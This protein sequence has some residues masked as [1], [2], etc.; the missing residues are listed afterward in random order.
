MTLATFMHW[1]AIWADLAGPSL[2]SIDE[3]IA[4]YWPHIEI[5]DKHDQS[6]GHKPVPRGAEICTS[7]PCS[8]W[9]NHYIGDLIMR[10]G[11]NI[12]LLTTVLRR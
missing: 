1:K 8:T 4:P 7:G 3:S 6:L 5:V 10:H 2:V 9:D 12:P 11:L